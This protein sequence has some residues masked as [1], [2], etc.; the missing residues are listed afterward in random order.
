MRPETAEWIEKAEGDF[1]TASRE[2][3]VRDAPNFSAVCFHSQ[4]CAEKYLK[5]LLVE[6]G[7]YFP[8]THNLVMLS[9]LL[10]ENGCD[11]SAID[12]E[13]N[14]LTPYGIDVRYPGGRPDAGAA[15]EALSDCASIRSELRA[16]LGLT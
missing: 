13:V 4:Q 1:L 15:Q 10:Q 8:K 2:Q 11:V 3:A 16:K 5:A 9:G 6:R 14:R 12:P 7:I